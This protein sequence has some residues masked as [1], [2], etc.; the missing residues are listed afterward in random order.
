MSSEHTNRFHPLLLAQPLPEPHFQHD[1]PHISNIK[2]P[3]PD[4][5]PFHHMDS[6]VL[7]RSPGHSI[8]GDSRIDATPLQCEYLVEHR[9]IQVY[10]CFPVFNHHTRT[11]L[12]EHAISSL[13]RSHEADH[14]LEA[15]SIICMPPRRLR[16][17]RPTESEPMS[18]MVERTP[19]TDISTMQTINPALVFPNASKSIAESSSCTGT[20][21]AAAEVCR[22]TSD[23]GI[24]ST[25]LLDP[26]QQNVE[27][28][29]DTAVCMNNH[30]L[31]DHHALR[32]QPGHDLDVEDPEFDMNKRIFNC[33]IIG[34]KKRFKRQDHLER[35]IRSHSKEKPYVCWVPGC[36][37]AFSRRDNLKVHCTKTHT[38]HGGHNRYVAT[39]DQKSPYYDPGFR[40]QL[41]FDGLPLRFPA[42]S[43]PVPEVKP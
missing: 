16:P 42:P 31:F 25:R 1:E 17:I 4:V 18:N 41:S 9:V 11:P 7:S 33:P 20:L 13:P 14:P 24:L 35:H 37:R 23:T 29:H 43:T 2:P 8:W 5:P 10:H 27:I 3:T 6:H 39:L 21:V 40:G 22:I 36:H 32:K 12:R 30:S 34:C 28:V 19:G 15:A 26:P 38:T